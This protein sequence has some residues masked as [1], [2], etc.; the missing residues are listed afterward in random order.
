MKSIITIGFLAIGIM[1]ANAQ[2]YKTAVGLRL[3]TFQG[4]TVKHNLS[5]KVALEGLVFSRWG[6]FGVTGLFELHNDLNAENL[7]WYYGA[8]GHVAIFSTNNISNAWVS[9]NT[10]SATIIGV[11]GILGLEYTLEGI[12]LNLSIDIKP[13]FNIIGSQ[14]LYLGDGALSVRY[15]F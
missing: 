8:G 1:S 5:E 10:G 11:D 9:N 14:G 4:L 3:G 7:K 15:A 12:P 13:I 6:G 2:A